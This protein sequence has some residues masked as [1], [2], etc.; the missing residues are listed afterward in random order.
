MTS[1]QDD[2]AVQH[3][4]EDE[5]REAGRRLFEAHMTKPGEGALRWDD[6]SDSVKGSWAYRA[7]REQA[8]Q[9]LHPDDGWTYCAPNVTVGDMKG[10]GAGPGEFKVGM[11]V[12]L[13]DFP[14]PY[15][16]GH[17][18]PLFGGCDDCMEAPPTTRVLRYKQV[19]EEEPRD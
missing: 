18:N 4:G 2:A 15:L 10:Y 3:D 14:F 1:S 19:W 9:P 11:L 17:V 16:V 5:Y 12:E 8:G 7:M 6:V 13:E